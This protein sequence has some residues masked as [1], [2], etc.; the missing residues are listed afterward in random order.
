MNPDQS[1]S[2]GIKLSFDAIMRSTMR[3]FTEFAYEE[4]RF[5]SQFFQSESFFQVIFKKSAEMIQSH[6]EKWLE[7]TGDIIGVLILIRTINWMQNIMKFLRDTTCM[8]IIFDKWLTVIYARFYQLLDTHHKSI[9]AA[10]C[11]PTSL[12]A[13]YVYII[14]QSTLYCRLL[15]VLHTFAPLF[16]LFLDRT[17]K[18]KKEAALILSKSRKL[19]LI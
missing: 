19:L 7:T 18:G 1:R 8:Q 13:H 12:K 4:H 15:F 9:A 3:L 2:H 14:L 10:K 5:V 6:I 16:V 11:D 17:K